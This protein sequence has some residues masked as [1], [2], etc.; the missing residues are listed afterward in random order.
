MKNLQINIIDSNTIIVTNIMKIEI[1]NLTIYWSIQF[2]KL[3][4]NLFID[5][6]NK[7]ISIRFD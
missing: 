3:S 1:H 5:L 7:I 4:I 6:F 2:L